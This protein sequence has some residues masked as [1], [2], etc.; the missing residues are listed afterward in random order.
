MKKSIMYLFARTPVHVGAGNSV[1]AVDSPV[2]RERHTR[3]P[4][5]PGSALK[6]T[7][8]D[9]WNEFDEKGKVVRSKIGEHLFGRGSDSDAKAGTLLIGEAR[10]LAFPVRSAKGC[11]AWITCPLVLNRYV[12]DAGLALE[13]E[14]P[15][16]GEM[17]CLSGSGVSYESKVVLEEYVVESIGSSEV[18]AAQL[19]SLLQDNVLWQSVDQHLVVLSN[20][21]FSYFVENACEVVTRNRIH[22]ETGTAE[23]GGLFSQEQV[24]SETLFYSVIAE[25]QRGKDAPG[26]IAALSAKLSELGGVLQVGGHETIGLGF[27]D[28]EVQ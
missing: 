9:F 1:G 2:M 7:L 6:G 4:I 21:L 25:Q 28:V 23:K 27:C 8:S 11:F 20:S 17:Q 13:S 3:I 18:V 15:V 24:P 14:L 10:V 16:F 19:K 22:D 5:I 26:A 12:R